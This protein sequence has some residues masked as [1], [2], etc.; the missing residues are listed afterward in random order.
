LIGEWSDGGHSSLKGKLQLAGSLLKDT[1]PT[2]D[3]PDERKTEL[4]GHN[5]HC[6]YPN[7]FRHGDGRIIMWEYSFA[8]LTERLV[9]IQRK[10]DI[11]YIDLTNHLDRYK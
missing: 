1:R 3:L 5:S 7:T 10:M 11:D 9:S 8:A 6:C 4:F 2:L